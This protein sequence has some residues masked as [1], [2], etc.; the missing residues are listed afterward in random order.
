MQE[1]RVPARE[2]EDNKSFLIGSLPLRLETNEGIAGALV[3]MELFELGLDYLERFPE[4]IRSITA[5]EIQAVVRK[6]LDPDRMVLSTAGPE[7]APPM[8]QEGAP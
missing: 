7:P 1:R 8:P 2:L 3:D 5:A 6:Y 4:I